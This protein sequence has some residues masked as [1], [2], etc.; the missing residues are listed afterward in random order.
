MVRMSQTLTVLS[1]LAAATQ[2]PLGWKSAWVT[3]LR[4]AGGETV[5][6][7][8]FQHTHTVRGFS[9]RTEDPRSMHPGRLSSLPSVLVER[10]D[11][12]AAG[13]VPELDGS[14]VTGRH[15]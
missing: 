11:A 10:V 7:K 1:V 14:V 4:R 6:K 13:F 5:S 12:L 3:Y 2:V 15:D 9:R 8:P